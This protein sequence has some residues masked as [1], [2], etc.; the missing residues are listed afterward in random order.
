MLGSNLKQSGI[1]FNVDGR[2]IATNILGRSYCASMYAS[3]N[4]QLREEIFK[5]SKVDSK[6]P[7][8]RFLKG[9]ESLMGTS[10]FI[11]PDGSNIFDTL[12]REYS[13]N[14]GGELDS[15][16]LKNTIQYEFD[17][18]PEEVS[19]IDFEGLIKGVEDLS[20]SKDTENYLSYT[21]SYKNEVENI[22][23]SRQPFILSNI[24]KIVGSSFETKHTEPIHAYI[25]YPSFS[26]NKASQIGNGNSCL[27]F[28]KEIATDISKILGELAYQLVKVSYIPYKT[29][30]T[31]TQKKYHKAFLKFLAAK[32]TFA[33]LSEK[34]AAEMVTD[35]EEADAMAKVYPY[36]LGYKYRNADREGKTP[37]ACIAAEIAR[38]KKYVE[39]LNKGSKKAKKYAS[40]NFDEY[41]PKKIAQMFIGKRGM[42]PYEFNKLPFENQD[43]VL[44]SKSKANRELDEK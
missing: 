11:H 28:G 4:P 29:T 38:D 13:K 39:S 22:W 37:E 31:S 44:K 17:L 26:T 36:W 40:Y 34:P 5:L 20:T 30:M 8:A 10:K 33:R 2:V 41:D 18:S 21:T 9:R 27:L 12:A 3:K 19:E 25:T 7:F 43:K 35:K 14:M 32:E 15:E 16:S 23:N 24:A 1:S 6:S 42:T